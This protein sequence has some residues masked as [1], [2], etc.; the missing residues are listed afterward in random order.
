[1][2]N[3]ILLENIR[4]TFR[5]PMLRIKRTAI[6]D[7]S[8]GVRENSIFGLLGPN[9]AGKTTTLK[10]ILGLVSPDSGTGNV[11][12]K[13]LGSKSTRARIG[14]LPEQ[15]YFYGF[16]T[17]EKAMMFYGHLAGLDTETIRNRS[18]KLLSLV[19]LPIGSHL[20]LEKYSKGMLQRFGIAQALLNDPDLVIMDEPSS[21]LDPVGQKEIREIIISLKE[22]GKTVFLSSHQLS[23]VESVCDSVSII[24]SG[25]AVA[26]GQL[27]DL[28]EVKGVSL[29]TFTGESERAQKVFSPLAR[30]V[31]TENGKTHVEVDADKVYEIITSGK[32]LGL[33][34][35]TVGPFRKTLE[36]LFMEI[37]RG[38]EI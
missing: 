9:G 25:R 11:L 22:R 15:P 21:G 31:H 4:K 37:V 17:A 27:D 3:V 32:E 1:M 8:L 10:V 20:T 36:D 14:F 24:N 16:M 33:Y 26:Q 2:D 5:S 28:L 7:L 6:S 19:G 12:G 13:P 30:K 38:Q 29:V 23:E 35:Q 34:L 18:E